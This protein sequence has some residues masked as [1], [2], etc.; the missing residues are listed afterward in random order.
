MSPQPNIKKQKSSL[1]PLLKRKL[2]FSLLIFTTT[3][4]ILAGLSWKRVLGPSK[5]NHFAYLAD[6]WLN[7]RLDMRVKPPHG[8]D[9]ARVESL[10]L[11]NGK[12][13]RGTWWIT[14]GK[15]IFRTTKG[16]FIKISRGDI[17]RRSYKY[18]VSFPPIPALLM[19]PFVAIWGTEFND[20]LFTL[21]FASLNP[22]LLWLLLGKLRKDGYHSRSDKDIIS[23]LVLAVFGTVYLFSAIRGEVWYTAH[24]IGITF[25]LSYLLA[26]FHKK[27]FLAGLALGAGFLTRT[28]LLMASLLVPILLFQQNGIKDFKKSI[29]PVLLFS[30][31]MAVALISIMVLNW[32]RF[33]NVFEFGH[34]YL[35]IRWRY[36]IEKYG[37]FSVEYISRNLSVALT[38]LPRISTKFPF[39]QISPHG[40]ALWL[41][42]PLFFTLIRFR[43][44]HKLFIPFMLVLVPIMLMVLSYQNSG[45]V[46]FGFRFSLDF[47]PLLILLLAFDKWKFGKLYYAF[48]VWGIAVNI[49]GAV[50][51]SRFSSF[52][53]SGSF[54]FFTS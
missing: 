53:P 54:L 8:N 10:E 16:E 21:L 13:L 51:F 32:L 50:T 25:L 42:T 28:P 43:G 38:L 15:D 7:K 39:V 35:Q 41:T 31:P 40:M 29:K 4:S 27:F 47:M 6:S 18:Y 44:R 17:R 49:F 22:I 23:L 2:L 3:F 52:Y 1:P 12:K 45:F 24:I 14:K 48:L 30:F 33:D 20:V 9:W 46:Q 36:R 19:V 5:N 11:K 26:L 34:N 37:L